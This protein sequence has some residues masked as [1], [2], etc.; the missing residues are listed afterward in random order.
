MCIINH[1]PLGNQRNE[2]SGGLNISEKLVRDHPG[3]YHHLGTM[4]VYVPFENCNKH[5]IIRC[6][7][8]HFLSDRSVETS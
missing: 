7:L 4:H 2:I 6:L 3:L 5:L 1:Y 8:Q